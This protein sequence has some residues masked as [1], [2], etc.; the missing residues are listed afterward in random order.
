MREGRGKEFR[1]VR[2]QKNS[3]ELVVWMSKQEEVTR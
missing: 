1:D 3:K 2:K